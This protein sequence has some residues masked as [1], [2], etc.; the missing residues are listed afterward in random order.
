MAA[1]AGAAPMAGGAPGEYGADVR[2]HCGRVGMVRSGSPGGRARRRSV[3]HPSSQRARRPLFFTV[4]PRRHEAGCPSGQRE[5]SVKPS[6]QPSM[7]RIHHLPHQPKPAPDQ[8]KRGQGL[9]S[10]YA[11]VRGSGWPYA[12]GCGK[13]AA[14]LGEHLLSTVDG[15]AELSRTEIKAAPRPAALRAGRAAPTAPTRRSAPG[16]PQSI[17][18]PAR[19]IDTRRYHVRRRLSSSA[20]H[21]PGHGRR[22]KG[23]FGVAS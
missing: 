3:R 6:A 2:C 1:R 9:V 17:H 12:A 4:P 23:A 21:C 19:L 22:P 14:K 20:L 7:V 13:Y 15:A 18:S 10:S 5:R 11:V 16:H 8:E